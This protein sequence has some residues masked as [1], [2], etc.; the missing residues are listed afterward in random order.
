MSK[1]LNPG[2]IPGNV[3]LYNGSTLLTQ[4]NNPSSDYTSLTFNTYQLPYSTTFT[5]IVSPNVTD[6]AG[7]HLASEFR[8]TFTT[9]PQPTTSQPQVNT[10]RPG[11]GSTGV[12][13]N[14]P[15][16]FFMSAPMNPATVNS[17][18]VKVSQNGVLLN[19]TVA[20]SA[21]NQD[22]VFTPA[23][24]SF[25][26]G[27]LIQ[28]WFTS[29]ATDTYGNQLY[30]YQSSFTIQQDLST[31][32]LNAVSYCPYCGTAE[33]GLPGIIEILMNKPVNPATAIPANFYIRDNSDNPVSGTISL[34]DNGRLLRFK[35]S[36]SLTQQVYYIVNVTTSLQDLNG[37]AW[38]G[39]THMA[40]TPTAPQIPFALPSKPPR[41]PTVRP[42]SVRTP[43][44]A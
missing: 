29:A 9:G 18:S 6:L 33:A 35:P 14:S 31:T 43:S 3:A 19:G 20:L 28:V 30:N 15:I 42:P 38:A 4:S 39:N 34:L 25:Q 40:S 16:T 8:S 11:S 13:A 1:S 7:N 41:Q 17:G 12:S 26:A 21:G 23:G 5:V 32:P 27:A 44:S 22:V 24:G 2:S 36:A 37:L 10:M